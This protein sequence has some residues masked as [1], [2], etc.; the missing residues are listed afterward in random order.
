M[1]RR[2][3]SIF[4]LAT[5]FIAGGVLHFVIPGRFEGVIPFWIPDHAFI[6]KLSGACEILGG[7]GLLIP[8]T[9][10]ATGWGLIV[11]LVAI[12]PANIEMLR[13]AHAVESSSVWR[14]ALWARLPLQGVLIWWVY[15]AGT[16]LKDPASQELRPPRS[17]AG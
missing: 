5:L 1:R 7:I 12:F 17:A 8:L 13:Q 4:L 9:R 10:M 6:V 11:L 2:S 15:R 16:R 14:I 3:W